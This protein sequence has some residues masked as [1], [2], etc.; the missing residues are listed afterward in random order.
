MPY[1]P[2]SGR[3]YSLLNSGPPARFRR[4][5]GAHNRHSPGASPPPQRR[6]GRAE[7]GAHNPPQNRPQIAQR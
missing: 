5:R 6:R 2:P 7:E 3:V 1:C 4:V